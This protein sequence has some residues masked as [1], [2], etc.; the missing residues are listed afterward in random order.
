MDADWDAFYRAISPRE[1][2]PLLAR[3]LAAWGDAPPGAA[4]DLGAGDGTETFALLASGWRVTAV[5]SSVASAG[6]LR[7][8]VG[9]DD[10]GSLE[11]QTV[12]IQ[13][14]T[15]SDVDLVYAGYSLPFIPPMH[16]EATWARI[17]AALTPGAILAADLFGP[18]D[19][20]AGDPTMNFHDRATVEALLDGLELIDLQ[21]QDSDGDA[22]SG[23]KHWHVLEFVARQ[24]G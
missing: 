9:A 4:L 21:E 18:H 8:G 7:D 12:A 10:A 15:F 1:P 2:R 20:W 6:R 19:S 14:A 11:I 17:R 22:V 5:D 24:P 16:F 13:Y 23:P 3:A